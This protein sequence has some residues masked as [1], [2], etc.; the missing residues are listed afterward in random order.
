MHLGEETSPGW[1]SYGTRGFTLEHNQ[2]ENELIEI[3]CPRCKTTPGVKQLEVD[4]GATREADV[5]TRDRRLMNLGNSMLH[6]TRE[7]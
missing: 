7:R 2:K 6:K 5:K 3:H 1:V 4:H